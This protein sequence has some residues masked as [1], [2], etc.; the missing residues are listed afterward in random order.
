M[1]KYKGRGSLAATAERLLWKDARPLPEDVIGLASR[2]RAAARNRARTS[3][4]IP[5][6]VPRRSAAADSKRSHTKAEGIR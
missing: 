4:N 3:C 2:S 5:G 6:F 1:L